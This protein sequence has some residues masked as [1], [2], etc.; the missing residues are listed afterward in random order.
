IQESEARYIA[1]FSGGIMKRAHEFLSD[2]SVK[3]ERDEIVRLTSE[4]YKRD[5]LHAL[6]Q[7]D[8]FIGNRDR[9]DYILEIMMSWFR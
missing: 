2:D 8:Y 3:K 6:M 7:A 4:V 1:A 9:I 5:R